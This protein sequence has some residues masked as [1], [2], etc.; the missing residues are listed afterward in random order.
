M[1][2]VKYAVII[3]AVMLAGGGVAEASSASSQSAVTASRQSVSSG[4]DTDAID[5]VVRGRSIYVTVSRPI[6]VKIFT[7]LGQLIVQQN[8]PAGTTRLN[9]SARGIYILKAGDVTRRITI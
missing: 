1:R 9:V 7:I 5:I 2:A 6:Q 3:A 4:E 8:L